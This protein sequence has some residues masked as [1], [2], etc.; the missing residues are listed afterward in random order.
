MRSRVVGL[1]LVVAAMVAALSACNLREGEGSEYGSMS[2][3]KS[4]NV[5]GQNSSN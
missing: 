4:D 2:G 5:V 3:P 1:V